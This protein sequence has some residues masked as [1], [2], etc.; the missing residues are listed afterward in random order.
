[1]LASEVER[2][3][4]FRLGETAGLENTAGAT[5]APYTLLRAGQA[6]ERT[7]DLTAQPESSLVAGLSRAVDGVLRRR[8]SPSR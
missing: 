7:G 6:S 1:M 4:V 3:E 5:N 2:L 8:K